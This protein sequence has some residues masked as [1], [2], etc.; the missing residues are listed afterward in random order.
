MQSD[1]TKIKL[2]VLN[3]YAIGTIMPGSNSIGILASSKIKGAPWSTI[4]IEPVAIPKTGIRLASKKDFEKYS[5]SFKG[6]ENRKE[7]EYL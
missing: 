4:N 7:Y 1:C 5:L 3:E 6:F 2:V